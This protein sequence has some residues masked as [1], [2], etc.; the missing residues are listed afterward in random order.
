MVLTK[1][2]EYEFWPD[3]IAK[4]LVTKWKAKKQVIVTGTSISGNPH[5]GNANDV[6]RGDAIRLAVKDLKKPVPARAPL[7]VKP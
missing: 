4:E 5:I 3:I 7:A 2:Q 6:I 1:E